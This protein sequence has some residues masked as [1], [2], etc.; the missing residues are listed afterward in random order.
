MSQNPFVVA[1]AALLFVGPLVRGLFF[2]PEQLLAAGFVFVVTVLWLLD[3]LKAGRA[4]FRGWSLVELGAALLPVAYGLAYAQA[5]HPQSALLGF[6]TIAAGYG[7][8][9][10]S[11]DAPLSGS[12]G[13]LL[14]STVITSGALVAAIGVLSYVGLVQ[15]P[16]AV[17]VP[18]RAVAAAGRVGS[19]LQYYNTLAAY[20][21]VAIMLS[22]GVQAPQATWWQTAPWRAAAGLMA[23]TLALTQSRGVVAIFPVA[24]LVL[25]ALAPRGRKLQTL[26]EVVGVGAAAL[27]TLGPITEATRGGQPLAALGWVCVAALVASGPWGEVPRPLKRLGPLARPLI[28]TVL[29]ALAVAAGV[30]GR[31]AGTPVATRVTTSAAAAIDAAQG[32]EMLPQN[33]AERWLYMQDAWRMFQDRPLLGGGAGAWASLFARYRTAPYYTTQTHSFY[34]QVATDTGAVGLIGL[35]LFLAGLAVAAVRVLR[36]RP[37]GSARMQL[38]GGLAALVMLLAHAAVDFDLSFLSMSTLLWV[39]AGSLHGDARRLTTEEREGDL[40]AAERRF[41]VGSPSPADR[42]AGVARDLAAGSKGMGSRWSFSVLLAGFIAASAVVLLLL[43]GEA[44]RSW[45]GVRRAQGRTGSAE[46]NYQ[47]ALRFNPR[48]DATYLALADLYT[49]ETAD[50]RVTNPAATRQLQALADDAVRMAQRAATLNPFDPLVRAALARTYLRVGRFADALA[51]GRRVGEEDPWGISGYEVVA[52]AEVALGV[53]ALQ[54]GETGV[55]RAHFDAVIQEG[56]QVLAVGNRFDRLPL[57]FGRKPQLRG[58][59]AL[60]MGKADY[61][62]RNPKEAEKYLNTARWDPRSAPEGDAWLALLYRSTG[63]KGK[64]NWLQTRPWVRQA[65]QDEEFLKIAALPQL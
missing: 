41:L 9:L 43:G 33:Q 63:P 39:L 46:R 44:F 7:L 47:R 48:D 49:Q 50:L 11:R 17:T 58:A 13:R 56:I 14:I 38:A 54:N 36:V 55:A 20:L 42:A 59:L 62:L 65:F 15:L 34:A 26:S 21:G 2:A 61:F 24:S 31:V 3:R 35:V 32:E 12:R 40:E 51:E 64:D 19:T 23:V 27:L 60:A 6:V 25:I 52:Q 8:F 18:W 45:A 16:G 10:M 57:H 28:A 4:V 30:Y 53:A 29:V 1:L 5:V 37:S 22:L